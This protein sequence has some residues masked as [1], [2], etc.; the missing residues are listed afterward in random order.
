MHRHRSTVTIPAKHASAPNTINARN[1]PQIEEPQ[2]H[3][4]Q[5]QE[6]ATV[7]TKPTRIS[8]APVQ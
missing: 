6:C 2:E 8:L 1:A 7:Q 4:N 5:L 3:S